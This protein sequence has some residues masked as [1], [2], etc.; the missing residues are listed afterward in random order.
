MTLLFTSCVCVEGYEDN[1]TLDG[2]ADSQ[3][4]IYSFWV[5]RKEE[6]GNYEEK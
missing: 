5:Y 6:Q 1:V 4:N 3:Q 2:T